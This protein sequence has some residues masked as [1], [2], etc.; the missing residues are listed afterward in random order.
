MEGHEIGDHKL[1]HDRMHDKTV[2]KDM[3]NKNIHSDLHFGNT[4]NNES[5]FGHK[6]DKKW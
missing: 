4:S 2:H 3:H 6:F 1:V 5:S